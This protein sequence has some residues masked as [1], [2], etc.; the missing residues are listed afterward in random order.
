M[1]PTL[2]EKYYLSHAQE[3]FGFVSLRCEHLLQAEHLAYLQGFDRLSEDAQCLLVRIIARKPRFLKRESLRY[4]EIAKLDSALR[5]LIIAGYTS[6][7]RIEDW[8]SFVSVLTKPEIF[9]CLTRSQV[10][11]KKSTSKGNMVALATERFN[12]DEQVLFVVRDNYLV[13]R[14][15]PLID[16]I[17][18]LYFGDLRNRFQ[19]FAMRDLGVLKT[20]KKNKNQ[21]ARFDN[22]A[23]ALSAFT[24]QSKRRDF[25]ANPAEVSEPLAKYLVNTNAVG[26]S[27]IELKDKLLLSVGNEL[28]ADKPDMA[29]ELW[30]ACDEPLATERW[31]R[32]V[33]RRRDRESLK[34]ELQQMREQKLPAPT[35]IFIEDFYT[36][37]YEGKRTSVYTDMLREPSSTLQIDESY[38]NDVEEGVIQHYKRQ[39]QNAYFAENK[40]WRALF[41]FTFWELLFGRDQLQH[42]EFDHL[43]PAL[44]NGRFFAEQHHEIEACLCRFEN[45]ARVNK[46]FFKLAALHYGYPTGLFRWNASVLESVQACVEHAPKGA[47][48]SVLRRMAQDFRHSKDGY[49]DLIIIDRVGLRFEEV[50]AP[51][52]VLRPNQLVSI[53]R[54]RRAGFAVGISQVEWATNP[55]QVYAVVDIETT[56][57][58]KGH[59]AITEIAVVRVRNRKIVSQWST[60]VNPGRPIPAFITHLTGINNQMVADAPIFPELVDELEAQL[61]DS[62][63]V[64]HNVGFDYSFIQAAYADMNRDFRKPKF[65]TVR[66]ARKTFPGLKSY[67]LGKLTRHLD[68]PLDNAHRALSD[69]KATA[70]LLILIQRA[71]LS[72]ISISTHSDTG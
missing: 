44:R 39:N 14:H 51:G 4:T 54:L 17:L 13:R 1:L 42:N 49:P 26:D 10:K 25:L 48:A 69:A 60:L 63:F 3:L 34:V 22:K 43:P 32:E 5:E 67:A 36:R 57:M 7:V 33:Y 52:D 71:R 12:G 31:V 58:R 27:A 50:K 30:R 41:A 8:K 61:K 45:P 55:N 6:T 35:R 19:K 11:V 53:N 40:H 38:I 66:N 23:A 16:Y 47:I 29:I 24:L 56:G 28:V 21:V 15:Q 72:E 2:P 46:D 65:C 70:D 20:P 37:K 9:N 18:F 68:I 59:H 64:A 62:I